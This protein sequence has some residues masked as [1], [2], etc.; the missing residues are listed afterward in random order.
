MKT[1]LQLIA[2]TLRATIGVFSLMFA[3]VAA[4]YGGIVFIAKTEAN[5]MESKVMAVR[6]ADMEHLNARFDDTHKI[7]R[8]IKE[9]IRKIK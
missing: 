8:E 5:A 1:I 2:P 3:V 7:L 6:Q 9:E 4:S